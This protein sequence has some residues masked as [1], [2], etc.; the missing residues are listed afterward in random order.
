MP[1]PLYALDYGSRCRLRELV[2]PREAY[3]LQLAAPHLDGLKP[4]Q[5]I[6]SIDRLVLSLN[7]KKELDAYM[8]PFGQYHYDLSGNSFIEVRCYLEIQRFTLDEFQQI[9]GRFKL[10]GNVYFQHCKISS[11]VIH[12]I[13][14]NAGS[15]VKTAFFTSCEFDS[16][17]SPECICKSLKNCE[18]LYFQYAALF[19]C[20]WIDAFVDADITDMSRLNLMS[21]SAK[22]LDIKPEKLFAF[23][24]KQSPDF[25][26]IIGLR[27]MDATV[28]QLLDKFEKYF[29]L[30]TEEQACVCV[31]S[32]GFEKLYKLP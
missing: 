25:K 14:V 4:I 11:A 19:K 9:F 15:N 23:I 3:D 1:F 29:E 26:L 7:D 5:K 8:L 16:S 31:R 22:V 32:S 20:N 17:V 6:T 28:E 21:V 24:K 27:S 18:S 10:I 13:S 30:A 12:S 2:T